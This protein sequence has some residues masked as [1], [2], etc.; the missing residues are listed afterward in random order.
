[1][2]IFR[3]QGDLNGEGYWDATKQ[4]WYLTR[5][6]INLA[7]AAFANYGLTAKVWKVHFR[8]RVDNGPMGADG[9]AFMFYKDKSAYGVP[10]SGSYKAFETRNPNNSRNPVPGYGVEFDTFFNY[11]CDPLY[12]KNFVGIVQDVICKSALIDWPFDKID[13]NTWH[14]AEFTFINGHCS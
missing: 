13:D 2:T 5:P 14:S 10:D 3:R 11:D 6:K 8:Y 12:E 1:M 4:A 7:I 9:F